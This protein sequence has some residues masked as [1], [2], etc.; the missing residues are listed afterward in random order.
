MDYKSQI[1]DLLVSDDQAQVKRG[2]DLLV[3]MVP[4]NPNLRSTIEFALDYFQSE[5]ND[6]LKGPI[7]PMYGPV[8]K[9]LVDVFASDDSIHGRIEFD[10]LNDMLRMHDP[11]S[12]MPEVNRLT[13]ILRR[14]ESVL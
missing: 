6:L 11:S 10:R 9:D 12:V 7:D 4:V 13:N 3:T 8:T 14:L 2:V 5:V 1:R